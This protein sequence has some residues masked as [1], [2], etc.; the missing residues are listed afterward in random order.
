MFAAGGAFGV[1]FGCVGLLFAGVGTGAL[2]WTVRTVSTYKRT[3]REGLRAEARC[4]E[5]YVTRHHHSDGYTHSRRHLVVG[6]RTAD[7]YDVRAKVSSRRPF[8]A[9]DNIPVRYLPQHPDRA[10]TDEAPTGVGVVSCLFGGVMVALTCL[11]LFF[12]A[13]GFGAALFLGASADDDG[14]APLPA[15]RISVR[16]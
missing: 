16:P 11:G 7:G 4:L 6:F 13:M 1:V 10:V 15:P 14:S 9:G 8:V 3:L 2:V 12:A 5:T